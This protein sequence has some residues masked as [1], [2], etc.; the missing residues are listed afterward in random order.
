MV[1]QELKTTLG[2]NIQHFR[3]QRQL[4]Q[5]DLAWKANISITNLSN[6]ER[7]NTFPKAG[8]ICTLAKCLEIEVY[9]LFKGEVVPEESRAL[10]DRFC[11]D[12][13]TRLIQTLEDVY[14]HYRK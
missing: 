10:M 8:T 14:M 13:T 6:I 1:E 2:K 4:S 12:I 5:A 7:G 11:E 3:C 9:D